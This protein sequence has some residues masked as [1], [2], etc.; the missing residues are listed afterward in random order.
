MGPYY[1]FHQTDVINMFFLNLTFPLAVNSSLDMFSRKRILHCLLFP[2]GFYLKFP[3][4][5]SELPYKLRVGNETK[6]QNSI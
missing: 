6:Q 1:W 4:G 3:F 2:F 5:V